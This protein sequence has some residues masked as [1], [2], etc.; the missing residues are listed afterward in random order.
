MQY[1]GGRADAV[2]SAAAGPAA[3]LQRRLGAGTHDA[4]EGRRE[5]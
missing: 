2:E 3:G 4:Q 5:V 1:G